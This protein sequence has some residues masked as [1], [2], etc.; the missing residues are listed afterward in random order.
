[1]NP[2]EWEEDLAKACRYHAYDLGSQ[3][4]F[5]HNSFDRNKDNL[6]EVGGTFERIRKFYNDTFVNSENIAAGNEGVEGTFQ[7]WYTS[8]GH[9]ENMFNSSSKKVGIGVCHIPGSTF[10]YY[11]VFCT[12]Q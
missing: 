12:A 10:G 11:W 3:G 5:D 2:L 8:K 9:Y 4:Y 1:M 7:Q 6:F